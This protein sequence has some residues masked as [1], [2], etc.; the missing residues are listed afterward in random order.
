RDLNFRLSLGEGEYAVIGRT[1]TS[2]PAAVGDD[3]D[4]VP[5]G[6]VLFEAGDEDDRVARLL[7]LRVVA[8]EPAVSRRL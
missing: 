8:A 4:G 5:L 2:G 7:V 1:E 3:E 6:G